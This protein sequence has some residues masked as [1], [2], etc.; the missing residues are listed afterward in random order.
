MILSKEEADEKRK[1]I[2][3]IRN[4]IENFRPYLARIIGTTPSEE[5]IYMERVNS[6]S[7]EAIKLELDELQFCISNRNSGNMVKHAYFYGM[8]M[9][10]HIGTN[11]LDLHL[12]GLSRDLARNQELDFIL[13]ELACIYGVHTWARPEAK[14]AAVTAFSILSVDSKNR[15][16]EGLQRQ[17]AQQQQ[18]Q[19]EQKEEDQQT[20]SEVSETQEQKE[21][22]LMNELNA[23]EV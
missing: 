6:L 16:I 8:G 14:L 5:V 15:V 9:V 13:K 23:F 19:P 3:T 18:Q 22:A 7:I 21:A 2:Q 11:Y 20:E 10:E 1:L 12:D 4:Y 17:N